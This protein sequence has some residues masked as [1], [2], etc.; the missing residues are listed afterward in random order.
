MKK[1]YFTTTSIPADSVGFYHN[2]YLAQAVDY[3]VH[4]STLEYKLIL[5]SLQNTNYDEM[6]FAINSEIS[7]SSDSIRLQFLQENVSPETFSILINLEN[8][9][10][11]NSENYNAVSNAVDNLVNEVNFENIDTDDAYLIRG[12]A[13]TLKSSALFWYPVSLGGSGR[14]NDFIRYEEKNSKSSNVQERR[15]PPRV[16]ADGRGFG[17][18]L[19]WGTLTTANP[20]TGVLA[21]IGGAVGASL[22]Y[23]R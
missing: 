20:G 14:G 2:L 21:G 3:A 16:R 11:N 8:A 12:Y 1:T 7:N 18:G 13:G 6:K 10:E 22:M 15:L 23:G 9:V 17:F 5:D 4:N 19:V